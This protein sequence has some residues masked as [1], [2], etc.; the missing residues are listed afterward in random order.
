MHFRRADR[1]IAH[2]FSLTGTPVGAAVL[3]CAVLLNDCVLARA[4]VFNGSQPAEAAVGSLLV[5]PSSVYT[6]NAARLPP[7]AGGTK[8]LHA[9]LRMAVEKQRVSEAF[10]IAALILQSSPDDET[11]RRI[12]GY[13]RVGES[14][15]GR[16]AALR[17]KQG[18]QWDHQLGWVKPEHLEK[19]RQGQR[20]LGSGWISA[21]ED[22]NRRESIRNGW[23]VRTDHVQVATNHSLEAAAAMAVRIENLYQLWRQ[24][25]GEFTATP[26][27]LQARLD[28]KPG[29]GFRR[30]PFRVVFHRS[31]DQY[32]AE[33]QQRQPQIAMT[34]GIYFDALEESHFFAGEEQDPGTINHE[35]VHQFFH[36]S[37][38][39]RRNVSATANAWAIEGVACYFES[40][41]RQ[42]VEIEPQA[43][44]EAVQGEVHWYTIGMLLAGRL[45]AARQRRLIDDY[46]VPLAKL[47]SLGKNDLQQRSDIAP[48]Y[49]QSAGLAS[50]FMDYDGGIYRTPFRQFLRNI[51]AGRDD[52]DTIIETTGKSFDQLDAQYRDFLES[53]PRHDAAADFSY[54]GDD[55]WPPEG[56]KT[57]GTPVKP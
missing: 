29:E 34:L 43:A 12:L 44:G 51:Y 23:T 24:L 8:A 48:L 16:L 40:L 49:S 27:E 42:R 28:G 53:L 36:E 30:K 54:N 35:A 1:R 13:E 31:R 18:F 5:V 4:E 6:P 3:A 2:A 38:G 39:A 52:V 33:L 9:R 17:T 26:K 14:W 11:A 47:S 46:Y 56:T 41:I 15:G 45:P 10:R 50:F 37:T 55:R 32:N 7:P 19:M 21:E 25:F 57:E 20:P 22:A